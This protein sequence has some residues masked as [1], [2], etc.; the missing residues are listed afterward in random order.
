LTACEIQNTLDL[1]LS[2]G[3]LSIDCGLDDKSS[4]YNDIF[5]GV[6][7]VSDGAYVD[8]GEN[9]RVAAEYESQWPRRYLTVRSFPTG[10]R[11]CYTLPTEA[12]GARY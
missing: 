5:T 10:T 1:I 12:A 11:N 7:Y 3:F 9:L 2:A 4:G 8:A 6:F